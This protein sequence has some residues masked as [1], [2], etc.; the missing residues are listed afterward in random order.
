MTTGKAILKIA[1]TKLGHEYELGAQI[2]VR[3]RDAPGPWDC[4]EYVSWAVYQ[5]TGQVWGSRERDYALGDGLD[6][7]TGWWN[8]DSLARGSRIAVPD[9]LAIPGAILLRAPHDPS[10]L[11]GHIALSTGDAGTL[12]AHSRA[13]GVLAFTAQSRF[14]HTG[15]LLPDVSYE[16]TPG[17][18]W[19]Q[20][21]KRAWRYNPL[22]PLRGK[23]VHKIK[24]KLKSKGFDGGEPVD[25]FTEATH[26]A[27]M[28][29]QKAKDLL[30]D[31]IVGL[32]TLR[33]L[34]YV[35]GPAGQR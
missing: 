13:R 7:Y 18:F 31:G 4:A 20:P 8:A 2:D 17:D 22:E 35:V 12:E 3:D 26:V 33:A 14:W 11:R 19:Y 30:V 24:R 29:F 21:A 1:R 25:V 27:V 23:Q 32:Q 6:S 16:R 34:G 15:L 28:A 9:A 5:A 10:A